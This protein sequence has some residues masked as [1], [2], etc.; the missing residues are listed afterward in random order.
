MIR[1][2]ADDPVL[3]DLRL[4]QA[5]SPDPARAERVRARC[6]AHL[7]RSRPSGRP[8]DGRLFPSVLVGSLCGVYIIGLIRI[9][10]RAY[11]VFE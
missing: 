9:A 10:L 1:N 3:K 5:L 11:G 8:V 6:R 7:E 4:L 2:D